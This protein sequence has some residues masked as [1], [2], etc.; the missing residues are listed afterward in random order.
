MVGFDD[1]FSNFVDF[2]C[3]ICERK[4]ASHH[5]LGLGARFLVAV[6]LI[7]GCLNWKGLSSACF[8]F[9]FCVCVYGFYTIFDCLFRDGRESGKGRFWVCHV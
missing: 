6:V 8:F 1:G 5:L 7:C 3:G 4:S 9:S 2:G